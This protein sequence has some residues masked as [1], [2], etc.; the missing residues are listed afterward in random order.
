MILVYI[1]NILFFKVT[2]NQYYDHG[3]CIIFNCNVNNTSKNSILITSVRLIHT[4]ELFTWYEDDNVI[5]NGGYIQLEPSKFV[6]VFFLHATNLF[7]F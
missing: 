3:S 5:R 7:L 1:N 4:T 6:S 2:P